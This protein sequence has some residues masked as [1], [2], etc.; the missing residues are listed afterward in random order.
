MGYCRASQVCVRV[1]YVESQVAVSGAHVQQ[2]DN[3]KVE[4]IVD[5]LDAVGHRQRRQ[6]GAH[7]AAQL[8]ASQYDQC[9]AVPGQ[10][11]AAE[12]RI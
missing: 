2:E 4:E 6:E 10:A 11:E 1:Y 8:S 12:D 5:E 7:Y 3:D 9:E